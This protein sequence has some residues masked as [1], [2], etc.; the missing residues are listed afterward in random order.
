MSC[1]NPKNLFCFV[2]GAY[3]PSHHKRSIMTRPLLEAYE[4]YFLARTSK[5]NYTHGPPSVCNICN[6]ALLRWKSGM[7][8]KPDLPFVIPML[9]SSPEDHVTDC[10][11][12][13]TR[14]DVPSGNVRMNA[15]YHFKVEYPIVRSA[16]R[17]KIFASKNSHQKTVVQLAHQTRSE[18]P[19]PIVENDS[20]EPLLLKT[21]NNFRYPPDT[22]SQKNLQPQGTVRDKTMRSSVGISSLK[23]K[24][25]SEAMYDVTKICL[26]DSK[27]T[28]VLEQ[29]EKLLPSSGL[30]HV[31]PKSVAPNNTSSP[32]IL[33]VYSLHKAVVKLDCNTLQPSVKKEAEPVM[34]EIMDDDDEVNSALGTNKDENVKLI[35]T[36]LGTR[37]DDGLN[38]QEPL[39][40][41]HEKIISKQEQLLPKQESLVPKQMSEMKTERTQEIGNCSVVE[42]KSH[43]QNP[44]AVP[45]IGN[46]TNL[47][48]TVI[49][50]GLVVVKRSRIINSPE[51]QPAASPQPTS[52]AITSEIE[53]PHRITQSELILLLRE[54]ELPKDKSAVLIERLKR[55][56]L[57]AP[58][59]VGSHR[60][61][62]DETRSEEHSVRQTASVS[63]TQTKP[64]QGVPVSAFTPVVSSLVR[65]KD[66]QIR[67]TRTGNRILAS[68][69]VSAGNNKIKKSAEVVT[70]V[71]HMIE[72]Q[73]SQQPRWIAIKTRGYS[74]YP[75]KT[76]KRSTSNTS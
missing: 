1:K 37:L 20:N 53:G 10:F 26:P 72:K 43:T 75:Q 13:L 58:Q 70:A 59:L 11:F 55:W 61:R 62:N 30:Q 27:P 18:S 50:N 67:S 47:S 32:K 44:V 16:I 6:N 9:W 71:K 42:Q 60:A 31:A 17:P 5:E 73:T 39:R 7:C 14:A 12:C 24:I 34:I 4:Q 57:L 52:P 48:S 69:I 40:P 56:N 76:T 68:P 64:A 65:R 35:P 23:R 45:T 54:L 8:H 66:I 28:V 29:S 33:N 15:L 38:N 51:E 63:Q 74:G 46:I 21:V 19:L 49:P 25:H 3:T 2:C 41:R 22:V 36:C